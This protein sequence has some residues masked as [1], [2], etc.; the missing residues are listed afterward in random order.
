M[1]HNNV[2]DILR[3]RSN[4]FRL[5]SKSLTSLGYTNVQSTVAINE[6]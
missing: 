2:T 4:L 6:C 5:D 1:W 3:N